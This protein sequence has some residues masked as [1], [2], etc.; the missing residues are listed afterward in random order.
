MDYVRNNYPYVDGMQDRFS[1]G[2]VM[3][4][5][6]WTRVFLASV[7]IELLIYFIAGVGGTVWMIY[8][9]RKKFNMTD[10]QVIKKQRELTTALLFQVFGV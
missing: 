9:H 5:K 2:G 6:P 1:C 3:L 7:A 8:K 4:S 10:Q